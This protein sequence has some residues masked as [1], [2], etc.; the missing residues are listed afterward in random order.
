[1]IR[2]F[3][4]L[5]VAGL[6]DAFL[7]VFFNKQSMRLV[8]IYFLVSLVALVPLLIVFSQT[9][10]GIFTTFLPNNDIS[11]LGLGDLESLFPVWLV[12]ICLVVYLFITVMYSL[13]S[14]ELYGKRFFETPFSFFPSFRFQLR[15]IPAFLLYLGFSTV[16]SFSV[17][18]LMYL[19]SFVLVAVTMALQGS[20]GIFVA[21]ILYVVL[22]FGVTESSTVFFKGILPAL[23]FDRHRFFRSIG[24]S[25]SLFSRDFFRIDAASILFK[26]L[27]FLG[28][29]ILTAILVA[30]S[31]LILMALNVSQERASVISLVIVAGALGFLVFVTNVAGNAFNTVLY[32]NQKVKHE[33][34][35]AELL[36]RGFIEDNTGKGAAP[37]KT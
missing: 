13:I 36:A 31:V 5:S 15:K 18:P 30:G 1:M 24:R 32:C 35:G 10:I 8:L 9:L 4:A 14:T 22:Y 19:F 3:R 16:Q 7:K 27:V 26:V 17:S 28:A 21:L 2:E 25:A 34:L 29:G 11:S 12:I 23:A 37:S 33:G 6:F 20:N